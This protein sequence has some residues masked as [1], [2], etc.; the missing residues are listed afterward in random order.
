MGNICERLCTDPF[1]SFGRSK[2]QNHSL[3]Q[4]QIR[5]ALKRRSGKHFVNRRDLRQL[6]GTKFMRPTRSRENIRK[7]YSFDKEKLGK[8]GFG[9][10]LKAFLKKDKT[11]VFAV[12]VIDK[13]AHYHDMALFLKEIE[14]LKL[15]D[16]PYIVKFYEVYE[17][18]KHL[19]LVQEFCAG[20]EL[21]DRIDSQGRCG[22]HDT[23]NYLWQMLV[24][25]NYIHKKGIAHR[26][27]KPQ[28]FMIKE[29]GGTELKMI[30]FGLSQAYSPDK[31]MFTIAGSPCYLSPEVLDQTYTHKCDVWSLGVVL[32]QLITGDLPFNS[33]N[34][35][36]IFEQI[37]NADYDLAKFEAMGVS[38]HCLDLLRRMIV[39]GEDKRI[40]VE[41][42]IQ[43]P[44]FQPKVERIRSVGKKLISKT[45]LQNL[46]KFSVSS[47]FQREMIGMMV[48]AFRDDIEI[49][50]LTCIFMSLN[51]DFSGTLKKSD[52]DKLFNSYQI[53]LT[54]QE[55][56]HI[57]DS[58]YIKDKGQITFLEFEA[59]MLD[60][61]FFTNDA[62][63]RTF[64]KYF[65]LDGDGFISHDEIV[66]CFRRFGREMDEVG[67]RLMIS[68]VDEN[69]DGLIS[70]KEFEL[71][72]SGSSASPVRARR[73]NER[74]MSRLERQ[75]SMSHP[76]IL[77]SLN[78][79]R[80][81]NDSP[82]LKSME[83]KTF[84]KL[85]K[86]IF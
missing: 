76:D 64:F 12:K 28:N 10:C 67:V 38:R 41:E 61:Q 21:Q 84:R 42:A 29:Y 71:L 36:E 75:R 43:H 33:V 48:Q 47:M 25:V 24:A 44:W 5:E 46:R 31:Y 26:D 83:I 62:R 54:E 66:S 30:D 50:N 13:S 16:H 8:G 69:S 9:Y 1:P 4:Y 40:S 6:S 57:I 18:K 74:F 60:S 86:K 65:D 20:G 35:K 82:D 63:V 51:E 52:L 45:H 17:D 53:Y 77:L 34:N 68:E 22:E 37:Y 49:Q 11:R 73:A 80:M 56:E 58:L 14:L 15:F 85:E 59:G 79:R 55:I 7:M 32:Y 72:M 3:I 81:S 2:K 27:L 70:F 39:I 23:R 78:V 19:Y